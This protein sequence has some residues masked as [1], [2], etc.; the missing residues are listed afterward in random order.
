MGLLF[1]KQNTQK[2]LPDNQKT[3]HKQTNFY[4]LSDNS[5]FIHKRI[6]ISGIITLGAFIKSI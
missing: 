6:K 2:I 5:E 3:T 1:K 4:F